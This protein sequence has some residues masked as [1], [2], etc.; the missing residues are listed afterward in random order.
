MLGK[1][2]V[3]SN[4][5]GQEFYQ[6]VTPDHQ[7]MVETTANMSVKYKYGEVRARVWVDKEVKAQES[8][9]ASYKTANG[10]VRRRIK[11]LEPKLY[12]SKRRALRVSRRQIKRELRAID[13]M[14]RGSFIETK[15]GEVR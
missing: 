11:A 2:K 7:L 8:I 9:P 4:P 6:P 3:F 13:K 10:Q 15:G 5:F 12:R 1:V 14:L